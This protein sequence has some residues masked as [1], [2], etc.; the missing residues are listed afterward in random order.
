MIRLYTPQYKDLWF[1][2]MFMADSETMSYNHAWGGTIPFPEEDWAD[3]FD[4]WVINH[5]NKRFYRY[6]VNNETN[7]FV[8]ETAYH[9]D[10]GRNIY[11]A[12]VIVYSAH[13]GKGYGSQ[14]LRLLCESAEANGVS[15]LHDDI[16]IDNPAIKMFL[17]AGFTEEYRTEEII[18]LRKE[19]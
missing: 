1:R 9:H 10:A 5:E 6:L 14:G 16:A 19:L 11:V 8:G 18:I 7:E 3:W 13:R 12:D 15:V 2:Q 4:Y 17:D